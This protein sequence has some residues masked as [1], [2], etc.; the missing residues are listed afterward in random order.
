MSTLPSDL[1]ALTV[2]VARNVV[3]LLLRCFYVGN[4]R[5]GV[6]YGILLC[7]VFCLCYDGLIGL[8]A[9]LSIISPGA[10]TC[11][12]LFIRLLVSIPSNSSVIP[13]LHL[14]VLWRIEATDGHVAL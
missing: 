2:I 3:R 5:C 7:D 4:C 10:R 12:P 9:S 1:V 11:S 6:Y 14:L 8:D 13:M